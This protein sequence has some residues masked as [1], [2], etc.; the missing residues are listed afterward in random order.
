MLALLVLA[1]TGLV[2]RDVLQCGDELTDTEL[3]SVLLLSLVVTGVVILLVGSVALSRGELPRL[4]QVSVR[5]LLVADVLSGAV[6]RLPWLLA[7]LLLH[8]CVLARPERRTV[9][10][11]RLF[12]VA[13]AALY[14]LELLVGGPVLLR[15][16]GVLATRSVLLLLR[17]D[18]VLPDAVRLPG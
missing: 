16:V 12:I 6:L 5:R 17:A 4:T 10:L 18:R 3:R 11:L 8:A 13:D 1:G 14:V 9:L 2:T 7:S 15:P